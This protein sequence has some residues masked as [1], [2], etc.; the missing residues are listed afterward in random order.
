MSGKLLSRVRREEGL[1]HQT[2][3]Y[4][5]IINYLAGRRGQRILIHYKANITCSDG[6]YYLSGFN[7]KDSDAISLYLSQVDSLVDAVR[8]KPSAEFNYGSRL[9][10]IFYFRGRKEGVFSACSG[11]TVQN[12]VNK[13][14]PACSKTKLE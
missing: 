4:C 10:E 14:I 3:L 7:Q 9:V 5:T 8:A 1:A 2:R 11:V 12:G 13:K 6:C